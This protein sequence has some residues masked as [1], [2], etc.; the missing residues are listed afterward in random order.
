MTDTKILVV[1]DDA[2]VR[3]S[4]TFLLKRAGYLPVTVDGPKDALRLVREEEF[5]LVLMDMNF[6]PD[7]NRGRRYPSAEAGQSAAPGF[8]GYPDDGMGLYL[9]GCTRHAGRRF[10]FHHETME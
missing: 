4:L 8:A 2:V 5:R 9:F 1:D 6:Y 7:N 3:S 10:R